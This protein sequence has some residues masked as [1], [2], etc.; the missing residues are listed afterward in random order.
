MRAQGI[1]AGPANPRKVETRHSGAKDLLEVSI[2]EDTL[3]AP[4]KMTIWTPTAELTRALLAL[5]RGQR[6][7]FD[8]RAVSE[9]GGTANLEPVDGSLKIEQ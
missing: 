2:L 1:A 5:K 4:A 8:V 6:I 7:A 3:S 9:F